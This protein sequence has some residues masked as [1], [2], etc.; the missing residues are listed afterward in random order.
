MWYNHSIEY[1]ST[2]K[3][4]EGLEGVTQV[5]ECLPSKRRALNSNPS[6][7]PLPP[8]KRNIGNA[9]AFKNTK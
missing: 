5:V 3:K 7:S 6:A 2:T 1:Y 4:N 8:Q 9:V